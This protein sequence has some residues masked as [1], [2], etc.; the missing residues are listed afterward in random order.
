MRA[1]ATITLAIFV[2]FSVPIISFDRNAYRFLKESD[3]NSI[4]SI[5]N[6]EMIIPQPLEEVMVKVSQDKNF[7]LAEKLAEKLLTH[8]S[9][10]H[11]AYYV[12]SVYLESKGDLVG[13]RDQMLTAHDLDPLNP[14]YI[15]SLG[16]FELNLG[17]LEKAKMYAQKV[18]ILNPDQQG[19]ILL[20]QAIGQK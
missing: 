7:I 17:N 9:S 4:S 1:A 12:K 6:S 11:Q 14:I 3:I 20:E 8:R 15:L 10:S 16:I 13:A 5:V 19:L 18:R 2:I